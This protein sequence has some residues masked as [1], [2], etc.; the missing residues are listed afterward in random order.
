M[1]RRCRHPMFKGRHFDQEI[2]ILCVRW[3]VTYKL[4][5]RDLAAHSLLFNRNSLILARPH[6]P[7]R[8]EKRRK[9]YVFPTFWFH[10][11]CPWSTVLRRQP[12]TE[13]R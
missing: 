12:L 13:E 3:Y 4:S 2:I 1:V 6:S 8:A 9:P 5:Y 11:K 10:G 7:K